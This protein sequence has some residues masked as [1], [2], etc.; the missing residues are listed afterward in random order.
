[1]VQI[2][3]ASAGIGLEMMPAVNSA[4]VEVLGS[5]EIDF[6]SKTMNNRWNFEVMYMIGRFNR[7][8]GVEARLCRGRREDVLTYF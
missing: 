6:E 3:L 8:Q 4:R 5:I 1:M 2:G 7:Q